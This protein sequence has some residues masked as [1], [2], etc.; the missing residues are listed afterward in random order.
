[1]HTDEYEISLNREIGVCRSKIAS[2]KKELARLEK[3][4]G[5]LT[6][7][8]VEGKTGV[9]AI[10]EKE[11]ARWKEAAATL[12]VWSARLLE[13]EDLYLQHKK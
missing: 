12:S 11:S 3:A 5:L 7:Q 4:Y 2:A 8:F 1:M 13:Y 10:P 6:E 9:I